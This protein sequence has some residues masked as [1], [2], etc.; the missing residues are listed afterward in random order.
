[1]GL[2]FDA[3]NA[4]IV[5]IKVGIGPAMANAKKDIIDDV[6]PSKGANVKEFEME[7]NTLAK[8]VNPPN[9][10]I[11]LKRFPI[12]IQRKMVSQG[13]PINASFSSSAL[14]SSRMILK[15]SAVSPA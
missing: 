2:P 5:G 11:T 14:A 13:T 12:P 15:T 10:S 1:N 7:D 4:S 6:I 9:V 3:F 8:S